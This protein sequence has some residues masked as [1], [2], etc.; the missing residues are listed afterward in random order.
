MGMN[1]L[2]KFLAWAEERGHYMIGELYQNYTKY[3]ERMADL[4]TLAQ[5][6]QREKQNNGGS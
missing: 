1:E 3:L 6:E 2:D 4:Q 5:L